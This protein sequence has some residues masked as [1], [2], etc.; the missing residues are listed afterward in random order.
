MRLLRPLAGLNINLAC[1]LF[2]EI[3]NFFHGLEKENFWERLARQDRNKS[4][5]E[6]YGRLLD[7]AMLHFS[8]CVS[9]NVNQPGALTIPISR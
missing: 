2:K 6:E 8:V 3:E 5:V 4:H 9:L 1:R 7:E